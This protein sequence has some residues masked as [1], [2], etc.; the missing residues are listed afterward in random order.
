MDFGILKN[1]R[2]SIIL[3]EKTNANNFVIFNKC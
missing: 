2:V 3:T 1:V